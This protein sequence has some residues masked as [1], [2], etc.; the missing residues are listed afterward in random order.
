MSNGSRSTGVS[1]AGRV[2]RAGADLVR[3]A[4]VVSALVAAFSPVSKAVAFG[5]VCVVLAVPRLARLPAA[6]DLVL[7]T[8]LLAAVWA[9]PAGW[10]AAAPWLDTALHLVLPGAVA[11]TLHLLLVRA[12][13]LPPPHADGLRAGSVPLITVAL[14]AV[15]AVVW[16]FYEWFGKDVL[17]AAIRAHY[18]DTIADLAAGLTSALAAGLLLAARAHRTHRLAGGGP[19]EAAGAPGPAPGGEPAERPAPAGRTDHPAHGKPRAGP[20][21]GARVSRPGRAGAPE[22][23]RRTG[24]GGPSRRA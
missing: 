5:L 20:A 17:G 23:V 13:L 22:D 7:G 10:Y 1:L 19:P 24:P 18:D 15:V 21:H 2:C 11:A 12:R 8:A 4:A 6:L 3:V 9:F 16:E 14:G